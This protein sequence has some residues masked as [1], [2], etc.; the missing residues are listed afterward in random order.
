MD[1][2][3]IIELYYARSERAIAETKEKYGRYCFSIA[4]RIL[5]SDHDAEECE[6]DTYLKVWESV[7][8]AKPVRLKPYVGR[9]AR[10][11]A[12][13]R[14]AYNT[15]KKRDKRLEEIANELPLGD[16]SQPCDESA[17]KDVIDRF[18][19]ALPARN[20]VIFLRRYWYCCT[21]RE[22][23]AAA[24]LTENN[25]KVILHR[26]CEKLKKFLIKEGITQ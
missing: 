9:I 24:K 25:V 11:L 6:N 8:P 21:V 16:C 14:Y 17:L 5:C 1:D 26:T 20:R 7:P 23:A 13:N 12:L 10:N 4:L 18:L 19:A 15:A 22:I 2:N 3:K